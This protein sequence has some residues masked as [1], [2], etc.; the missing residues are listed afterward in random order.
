MRLSALMCCV[1]VVAC[2]TGSHAAEPMRMT[3]AKDETGVVSLDVCAEGPVVHLLLGRRL[4]GAPPR[5]EY[6]RSNDSGATWSV[7][8]SVGESQ[9]SPEPAHRGAD[10]QIA[11]SG[12][13]VVAVWTT[14]STEDRFGRGPMACAY[15]ADGGKTW[16]PGGNPADDGTATGHA[17]IDIAADSD[18][19]FH[20]VWLDTRNDTKSG[21]TTRPSG[22]GLRYARSIDGGASWSE[23]VTLDPQ[24]CECCWNTIKTAPGGKVD[25]L[26]RSYSPRDMAIVRSLDAGR[27]WTAPVRVGQFGWNI[28]GCP[29]VGGGLAVDPTGKDNSVYAVVWTAKDDLNHGAY[30]LSSPDGGAT[31][32][33]PAH[34]GDSTSWHSDIARHDRELIAAWDA[35]RDEKM[36]TFFARSADGAKTWSSPVQLSA[37]AASATHPRAISTPA[38]F[39]IFWTEQSPGK[40]SEWRE[41]DV[42]NSR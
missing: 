38:G 10:A 12:N 23:N 24:T 11:A 39:R 25:V 20:I 26:Y 34:L 17:F 30:V 15:S 35:F 42:A 27:T 31:W 1:V 40:P 16:T 36:A 22:K 37:P 19:T 41:R 6:L 33:E 3:H 9:P 29:H 8:V 7:P 21:A 18:G 32:N 13:R 5:L 28:N 4:P 2:C 14:G